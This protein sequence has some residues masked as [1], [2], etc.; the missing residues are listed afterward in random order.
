MTSAAIKWI[1]QGVSV[2][3]FGAGV[4][5][6]AFGADS[7]R[8]AASVSNVL[9]ITTIAGGI[10]L[11]AQSCCICTMG[12]YSDRRINKIMKELELQNA[13]L[14]ESLHSVNQLIERHQIENERQRRIV[15]EAKTNLEIITERA[16]DLDKSSKELQVANRD[17]RAALAESRALSERMAEEVAF[18][19]EQKEIAESQI[20]ELHTLVAQQKEQIIALEVQARNLNMLQK[21]SVA[22]IQKLVMYGNDCKK[23]GFEL[24]DIS[25]ELRE[26]DESL[27]LTANEMQHQMTAL[28]KVVT[29]LER[30]DRSLRQHKKKAG[31]SHKKSAT[32]STP[33]ESVLEEV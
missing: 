22:M 1:R 13:A 25:K 10:L 30:T 12:A 3:G 7:L 18:L 4:G 20:E 31:G 17:Y 33:L 27:G 8:N 14:R 9:G 11:T 16:T 32:R 15:D 5:F 21:Q 23:F 26:T 19:R 28:Q 24:K 6:I 29:A 2:I